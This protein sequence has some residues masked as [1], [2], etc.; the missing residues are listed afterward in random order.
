M[1]SILF[2]LVIFS[3]RSIRLDDRTGRY[4]TD[5]TRGERKFEKVDSESAGVN[6]IAFFPKKKFFGSTTDGAAN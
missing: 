1:R 3:N 4:L 5:R 6:G 2:F